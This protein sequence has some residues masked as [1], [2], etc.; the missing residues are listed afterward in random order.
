MMWEFA[1]RE[2][3]CQDYSE[4]TPRALTTC[5]FIAMSGKKMWVERVERLLPALWH[6]LP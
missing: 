6:L 5:Q 1:G 2:I 3:Q 4:S